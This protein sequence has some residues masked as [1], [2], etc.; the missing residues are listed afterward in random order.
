VTEQANEDW[1]TGQ[2]E[3]LASR[4]WGITGKARL[5]ASERDANFRIDPADGRAA[6]VL[7]ITHPDEDPAIAAF[8]SEALVHAR[9]ADP[10]LPVPNV[11]PTL[12]GAA[13]HRLDGARPRI[14]RMVGWLD[15]TPLADAPVSA[16]FRE[17]AG[18]LL[19][20]L[21]LALHGFPGDVPAHE[22]F[23][24]DLSQAA[25]LRALLPH[26][27]DEGARALAARAL[28]TFADEIAPR[29]T[30]MRRQVIHNDMNPHNILIDPAAP[31]R[32]AAIIDF[33]DMVEAPLVNEL[34]IA[35]AYQPVDG[36]DPLAAMAEFAAG[37]ARVL[38]LLPDEVDVLPGL[39]GA[40]RATTV[41][42]SSWR[43]ATQPENRAYLLR[44]M[45]GAVAGLAAFAAL[46]PGAAV[47]CLADACATEGD[48][49]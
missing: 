48:R 35:L 34:G 3:V 11:M 1:T 26:V 32:P 17:A 20:R 42:V 37:Y 30:A 41:V 25:A 49:A 29:L 12:S 13:W 31:H 23:V 19:A 5:L 27:E 2:A 6:Q 33:G 8:Q 14:A 40:R 39:I 46:T 10:T 43:A 44:N 24:W 21:D 7:K 38:P 36:P 47:A 4:I 45:P 9:T 28:D 18:A 22:G 16:A 15:G